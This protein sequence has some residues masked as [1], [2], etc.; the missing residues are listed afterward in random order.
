MRL[1]DAAGR[2]YNYDAVGMTRTGAVPAGFRRLEV[3]ERIGTAVFGPAAE[4]L[5]HWHAQRV[6]GVRLTASAEQV[7]EGAV[8]VARLGIGT[9]ALSA[10]C[11]VVWVTEDADRVGFAYGTLTGHLARGEESFVL[12]R[13]ADDSVWFTVSAYSRPATWYTRLG[14]PLVPLMQRRLARQYV[15]RLRALATGRTD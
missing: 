5:L 8:S 13:D 6:T 9:L 14:G 10:P 11:R 2:S 1:E 12:T 3:R 7:A 15:A 4:A